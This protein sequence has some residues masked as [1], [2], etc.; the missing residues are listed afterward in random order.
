MS[1]EVII[2]YKDMLE[3]EGLYEKKIRDGSNNGLGDFNSF[4]DYLL[5]CKLAGTEPLN[6]EKVWEDMK[7]QINYLQRQTV[8]LN[9]D[10]LALQNKIR[11][12]ESDIEEMRKNE[13][14]T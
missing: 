14:S 8:K 6:T 11:W 5:E 7:R 13:R 4:F 12:L 3:E 2:R 10:Y 1:N 9:E